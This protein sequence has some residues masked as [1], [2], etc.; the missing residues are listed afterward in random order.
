MH[1]WIKSK[2]V[3]L[4]G[5][6]VQSIPSFIPWHQGHF[7]KWCRGRAAYLVHGSNASSASKH[8]KGSDLIGLVTEAS[9]QVTPQDSTNKLCTQPFQK[10]P[11]PNLQ[12][13]HPVDTLW[14]TRSD[15]CRLPRPVCINT[16]G[17]AFQNGHFCLLMSCDMADQFIWTGRI[18]LIE[19]TQLGHTLGPLAER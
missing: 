10:F 14:K 8:A 3:D 11:N 15:L 9:L 4:I 1:Y 19:R 7:F 12:C 17:H 18:S 2:P 16:V 13:K 5:G 6:L